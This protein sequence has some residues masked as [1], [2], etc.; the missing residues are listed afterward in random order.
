MRIA[1]PVRLDEL[2]DAIKRLHT[3]ALDQLADA[4]L[5]AEHL[6]KSPTT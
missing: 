3:D 4:V 5:A 1:Y 6:A 2:I